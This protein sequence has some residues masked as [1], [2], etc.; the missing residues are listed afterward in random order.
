MPRASQRVPVASFIFLASFWTVAATAGAGCAPDGAGAGTEEAT[1][2]LASTLTIKG[3]LAIPDAYDCTGGTTSVGMTWTACHAFKKHFD[4]TT[5]AAITSNSYVPNAQ[6]PL[7]AMVTVV[8]QSN[9]GAF[10]DIQPG[11]TD[12]NGNF[13]IKV[14]N[15]PNNTSGIINLTA[16]LQY[17]VKNPSDSTQT[18]GTLR[19]LWDRSSIVQPYVSGPENVV[20]TDANGSWIEPASAPLRTLF[21]LAPTSSTVDIGTQVI[22]GSDFSPSWQPFVRGA[23]GMWQNVVS[24]H[25]KARSLLKDSTSTTPYAGYAAVFTTASYQACT[26]CY[27][28][29]FELP[30]IGSGSGGLGGFVVGAPAQ[31]ITE[32]QVMSL[33]AAGLAAH[34]FGHSINAGLAPS[35]M[36]VDGT[37][38]GAARNPDGSFY[39]IPHA[40]QVLVSSALQNQ[41]MALAMFEGFGDAMARFLLLDACNGSNPVTSVLGDPDML[42]TMWDVPAYDYCDAIFSNGCPTHN[43]RW[44]MQARGITE[45]SAEWNRRR[46][47]LGALAQTAASG[48]MKYVLTNNE[49]KASEL[50]CRLLAAHPDYTTMAGLIKGQRY[51]DDFPFLASEILDGRSPTP[52]WRTYAGDVGTSKPHLSLPHLL[53]AMSAICPGCDSPSVLPTP[54][55]KL[56]SLVDGGNAAYDQAWISTRGF[57]SPQTLATIVASHGWATKAQLNTA[58]RATYME[59]VP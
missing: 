51:I 56:P 32:A 55:W 40:P 3:R 13:S 49:A 30:G 50:Y 37:F 20:F 28:L 17:Q 15:C 29:T 14:A 46:A 19:A 10:C 47:A 4:P 25:F 58:L 59:E 41:D 42:N 26:N 36:R 23:L 7:V 1:S 22:D 57:F 6:R 39:A 45:G 52:V 24:L 2:A 53:T 12:E 16:Q 27:S 5:G 34:E 11:Q 54:M 43:F 48:G 44:Q 31:N 18:L 38:G 35:T 21:T 8:Y 9:T 33:E